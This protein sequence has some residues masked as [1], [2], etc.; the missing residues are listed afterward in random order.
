[1]L[2]GSTRKIALGLG[3]AGG[4]LLTAW[5]FTGDRGRKTKDFIVRKAVDIRGRL[6]K[7]ESPNDE[8]DLHYL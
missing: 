8:S 1:M 5:L 2:M 3:L 6:R 7:D 4:A